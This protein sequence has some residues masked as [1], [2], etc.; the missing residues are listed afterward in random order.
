VQFFFK[1]Y[2]H[3]W[4]SHYTEE[5]NVIGDPGAVDVVSDQEFWGYKDYGANLLAKLTPT[6]GVEYYAGYDFQNYSGEDAV[7]LIAAN[8]RFTTSPP[9]QR[10]AREPLR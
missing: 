5:R 10:Q 8:T 7:L 2:Y 1:G 9:D 3:R 6:R 4:D